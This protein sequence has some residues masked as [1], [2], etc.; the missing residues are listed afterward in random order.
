[1]ARADAEFIR[2]GIQP[3]EVRRNGRAYLEG[4]LSGLRELD[5]KRRIEFIDDV[6]AAMA[7]PGDGSASAYRIW[8]A[9]QSWTDHESPE[10]QQYVIG[11]ATRQADAK[12]H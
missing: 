8:L 10:Y 12:R 4:L 11:V 1:M 5:F 9:D 3:S 6:A 7:D 2:F